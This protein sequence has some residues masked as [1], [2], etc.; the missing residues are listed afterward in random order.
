MEELS[1]ACET[2]NHAKMSSFVHLCH[3]NL[4]KFHALDV[5]DRALLISL[6]FLEWCLI[7][8]N[9]VRRIVPYWLSCTD[10][11]SGTTIIVCWWFGAPVF[12]QSEENIYILYSSVISHLSIT[13]TW[14]LMEMEPAVQQR[15]DY[16]SNPAFPN[17]SYLA[18]VLT[19]W[20]VDFRQFVELEVVCDHQARLHKVQSGCQTASFTFVCLCKRNNLVPIY[21]LALQ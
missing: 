20:P 18:S 12:L 8:F 7:D 16:M 2:R 14:T 17:C 9:G 5:T 1:V 15:C 6:L 13:I 3:C 10:V 4:W 21:L 19:T 11:C